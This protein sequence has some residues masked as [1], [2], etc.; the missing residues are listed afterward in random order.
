V[1]GTI[2]KRGTTYSVVLA[3]WLKSKQELGAEPP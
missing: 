3:S 1:K 2:I